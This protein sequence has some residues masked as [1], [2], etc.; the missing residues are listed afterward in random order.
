MG[1]P[2][3]RSGGG[4]RF[5]WPFLKKEMFFPAL[6]KAMEIFQNNYW[7]GKER[8]G[9]TDRGRDQDNL[10]YKQIF[11]LLNREARLRDET[12]LQSRPRYLVYKI[13][14]I[15]ESFEIQKAAYDKSIEKIR[16]QRQQGSI[17]PATEYTDT[18]KKRTDRSFIKAVTDFEKRANQAFGGKLV[19]PWKTVPRRGGE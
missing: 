2:E 12:I 5:P 18:G 3:H 19:D 10:S 15:W 13:I 9:R 17:I 16:S 8:G 11:L 4:T 6:Q 1:K 7:N 14:S